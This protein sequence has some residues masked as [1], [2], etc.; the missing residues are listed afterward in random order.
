MD[1]K[2][3]ITNEWIQSLHRRMNLSRRMMTT[4]QATIIGLI[5]QEV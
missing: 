1:L 4:A 5:W 2:F 3:Y